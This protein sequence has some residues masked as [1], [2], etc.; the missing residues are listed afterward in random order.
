MP[1]WAK[2]GKLIEESHNSLTIR[3]DNTLAAVGKGGR[4]PT[5]DYSLRVYGRTI[6][7]RDVQ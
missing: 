2:N 7:S 1:D 6:A 5:K 4:P 3:Y